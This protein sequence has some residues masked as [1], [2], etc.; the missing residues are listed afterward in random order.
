MEDEFALGLDHFGYARVVYRWVDVTFHDGSAVVV[1]DEAV[2]ACFVHGD[3]LVKEFFESLG[4][5]E[6]FHKLTKV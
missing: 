2:I 5:N 6:E 3:I 4:K 1:L